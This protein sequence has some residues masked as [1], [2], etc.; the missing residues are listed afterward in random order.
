MNK[1]NELEQLIIQLKHENSQLKLKNE[2][3]QFKINNLLKTMKRL[4]TKLLKLYVKYKKNKIY[5]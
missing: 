1:S 3:I 2:N 5:K 4:E